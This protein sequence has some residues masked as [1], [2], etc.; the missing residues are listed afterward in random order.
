[1]KTEAVVRQDEIVLTYQS[2]YT[3]RLILYYLDANHE[4]YH[5]HNKYSVDTA[6]SSTTTAVVLVHVAI[7]TVFVSRSSTHPH[8]FKTIIILISHNQSYFSDLS[9]S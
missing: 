1:M 4:L 8:Q 5:Q 9:L 6:T 3:T 2:S 7:A